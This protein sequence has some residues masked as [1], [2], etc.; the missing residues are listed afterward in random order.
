MAKEA[1]KKKSRGKWSLYEKSGDKIN[2]KN[3]SCPKCGP[4]TF[5]AKH[6]NRWYCGTCRYVEMVSGK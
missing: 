6:A 4:G 1:A 2:R 3:K 5:M